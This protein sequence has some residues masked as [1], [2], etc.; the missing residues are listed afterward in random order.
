M[1]K[2]VYIHIYIPN[3]NSLYSPSLLLSSYSSL[4]L[5]RLFSSI[6]VPLSSSSPLFSFLHLCTSRMKERE[7]KQ[8]THPVSTSPLLSLY[9]FLFLTVTWYNVT[10]LNWRKYCTNQL[11]DWLT[12]WLTDWL[13]SFPLST[14]LSECYVRMS[15]RVNL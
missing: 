1:S 13:P 6:S 3:L 10:E 8:D 5:S 7:W 2:S 9:I 14:C 12:H 4:T 15:V 11:S